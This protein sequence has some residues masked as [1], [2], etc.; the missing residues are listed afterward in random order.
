MGVIANNPHHLAGAIDSDGADKGARFL[1]LCDAFDIPVLSLMD[2][3]GIMVGPDHEKT[4]LVRHCARMFNTGANLSVPMFG[5]VVRKAYGLGVQAMCG[6]SSLVGFFTVGWP[7]AEFAGHEHRGRGQARLPQ[8]AGRDR[9]S[10]R[11]ATRVRA[12]GRGFLRARQGGQRGGW[13]RSRRRDRSS[14]HPLLDHGKHEAAAASAA[15]HAARS[16]PTSILGSRHG[17]WQPAAIGSPGPYTL[18]TFDPS[19]PSTRRAHLH[20]L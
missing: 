8:G 2:C 9:G 17:T 19:N 10:R 6:A 1:Q 7:T 20:G 12:A 5:V 4:A 3:P 16:G 13:R 11:T 14:G 18:F 15:A